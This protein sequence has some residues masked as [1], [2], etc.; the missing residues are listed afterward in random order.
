M[1]CGACGCGTCR[2]PKKC[3][4]GPAGVPG[5]PGIPGPTGGTGGGGP[6]GSRGPTGVTGPTGP[7]CTGP[8]GSSGPTGPIGP[9]GSSV[10]L[11]NAFVTAEALVV[12][13]APNAPIVILAVAVA[14]TPGNK[15]RYTAYVQLRVSDPTTVTFR[16]SDSVDGLIVFGQQFYPTVPIFLT[17][18]IVLEWEIAGSL[19]GARIVSLEMESTVGILEA[20]SRYLAVDEFAP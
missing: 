17:D 12:T 5:P 1:S 16:I 6:T 4:T 15:V 10:L 13:P 20:S 7:C 11:Q 8:T 3:P 2:C 14:I 19:G 9:G 18:T